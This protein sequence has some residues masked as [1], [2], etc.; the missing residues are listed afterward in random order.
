MLRRIRRRPGRSARGDNTAGVS[1]LGGGAAGEGTGRQPASA[2]LSDICL[3]HAA[4]QVSAPGGP[5][6]TLGASPGEQA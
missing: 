6:E 3:A 2:A 1:L 4:S 5:L